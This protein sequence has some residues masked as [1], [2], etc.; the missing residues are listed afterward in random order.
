MDSRFLVKRPLPFCKGCSHHLVARAVDKA[1]TALGLDPLDVVVVT[2]IGCHGIIDAS[3]STHTVHGQHGRS[4]AVG[5]GISMGL[6]NPEKKI[7]V[8]IG[9]GGTTIGMN[10]LVGAAH[11]NIDMTV[12][13][14]SNMLYGM[15]GGQRSDLTPGAFRTRSPIEGFTPEPLDVLKIA[16]DAGAGFTARVAARGGISATI[17]EAIAYPGFALVDVLEICPA[18]GSKENPDLKIAG[19]EEMLGL[20]LE[21]RVEERSSVVRARPRENIP[22]LLDSLEPVEVEFSHSLERPL[23]ILLAGSAG[24]GVQSAADAF[25][26]AAMSCGLESTQKGNYPVTVG[27]GF[28]AAEIILSPDPI[29]FTG[30]R[31]IDW[32]VASSDDGMSYLTRKLESLTGGEILADSAVEVPDSNVRPRAADFRGTVARKDVN[33]LMLFTLLAI[34]G[35]FPSEALIKAVRATKLG[36]KTDPVAL[37][38]FAGGMRP[39]S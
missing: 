26:I 29:E 19:V 35:I 23:T 38:A 20:P 24:E 34:T 12:V 22:S 37:A 25:V 21:K 1:L 36:A 31:R 17:A 28:S 10:H 16:R 7:L 8:M 27:T 30:V 4:V 13:V 32:A 15:T 2:D 11:R 33:I 3:L 6:T 5:A 14:H 18:Y 9:D 39:A